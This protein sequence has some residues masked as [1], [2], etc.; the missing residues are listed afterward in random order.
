[1]TLCLINRWFIYEWI[2]VNPEGWR[3]DVWNT[4]GTPPCSDPVSQEDTIIKWLHPSVCF[5]WLIRWSFCFA[6]LTYIHQ[7]DFCLVIPFADLPV[8]SCHSGFE[9][10]PSCVPVQGT[11]MQSEVN[12]QM[13]LR[14]NCRSAEHGN[15]G[16]KQ[17]WHHPRICGRVQP[18]PPPMAENGWVVGINT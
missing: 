10:L 7:S 5:S 13:C 18:P 15:T 2:R 11:W 16:G 3:Q 17:A 8:G 1:M 4:S 14:R 6:F 9:P 12:H